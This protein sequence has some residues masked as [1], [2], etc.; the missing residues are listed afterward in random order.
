MSRSAAAIA[1]TVGRKDADRE[2]EGRTLT[3]TEG[4]LSAKITLLG[5]YAAGQFHAASDGHG[6]TLVTDPPTS[7]RTKPDPTTS[8]HTLLLL[9]QRLT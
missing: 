1:S 5:Q 2:L 6:G 9:S 7:E 4:A 3:V 8:V